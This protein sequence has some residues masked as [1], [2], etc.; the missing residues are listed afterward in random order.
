LRG[1]AFAR[2]ALLALSLALVAGWWTVDPWVAVAVGVATA[3]GS[4]NGWIL[5]GQHQLPTARELLE[6]RLE[7]QREPAPEASDA[8]APVDGA[9]VDRAR[10][11][12]ETNALLAELA[13]ELSGLSRNVATLMARLN[14]TSLSGEQID[15]LE[16]AQGAQSQLGTLLG[17]VFDL[18]RIEA[19]RLKLRRRDFELREEVEEVL[20]QLC[21]LAWKRGLDLTAEVDAS[22]PERLFADPRRLRQVIQ[23]LL[24]ATLR[25]TDSGEVFLRATGRVEGDEQILRLEIR[26]TAP[27]R[28]TA[29]F[30]RLRKRRPSALESLNELD[31]SLGLALAEGLS[32]V[33]GGK[34]G[35]GI[36][37]QAGNGLWLEVPVE[38]P[39]EANEDAA[40]E[41]QE[42]VGRRMLVIEARAAARE[43]LVTA[44]NRLGLRVDEVSDELEATR[45][46]RAA[47]EDQD[48]IQLILL[49][50]GLGGGLGREVV[51][52][53]TR[54][55]RWPR[56]MSLLL[57][58]G[59]GPENPAE[60]VRMGV[61]AWVPKPL[62]LKRLEEGIRHVLAQAAA[63][64][65]QA[66]P[67]SVPLVAGARTTA[68]PDAAEVSGGELDEPSPVRVLL[69]EPDAG[70]ARVQVA[71][72]R[73][74][75]C[76][77]VWQDEAEGF[78]R[79][80]QDAVFDLLLADRTALLGLDDAGL[81]S[82]AEARDGAQDV[83]I[84]WEHSP[85]QFANQ[86]SPGCTEALEEG[87]ASRRSEPEAP[88]PRCADLELE[89]PNSPLAV[90]IL[91]ST[92]LGDA[93]S[94]PT[95][96]P[97]LLDSLPQPLPVNDDTSP[98][99]PDVI[100]SLKDLGGED[101][102]ELF[103]E[104]VGM[105]LRDTPPRLEALGQALESGDANELE[106]VAHAMKSSCGNLGAVVMAELCYQLE[107]VG[108]EGALDSAPG[109]V[110]RSNEEFQRVIE[111][112]ESELA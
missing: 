57:T 13:P 101:E 55:Q 43:T 104:L 99:D 109:L 32:E 39:D 33:M 21:P 91:L 95:E 67:G 4:L 92:L 12:S 58:T 23:H 6:A 108:R 16:A 53:L 93:T 75:G 79:Q 25:A 110:Q 96:N 37:G 26:D 74:F 2:A 42:L 18:V 65:V 51:Q 111:A 105:F 36:E 38:V 66:E 82:L 31:L 73:K 71:F 87:K 61:D 59:G 40:R 44:G 29:E 72:L 14:D 102:P 7:L 68:S 107:M 84:S 78:L 1:L 64:S 77:V 50:D 70:L 80:Y 45:L 47:A 35:V 81:D 56:P 27:R 49:D 8:G 106:R 11:G 100:Q 3:A 69:L 46:L 41:D 9:S 22:V 112:L 90:R 19:G 52:R 62:R 97:S 10:T 15:L 60:L 48:P 20:E 5:R 89:K 76:R 103:R 85:P 34:F 28:S 54:S 88:R 24:R 98:I 86:G 30:E 94:P 63:P 83:L 17:D